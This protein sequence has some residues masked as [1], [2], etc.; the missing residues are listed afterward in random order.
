MSYYIKRVCLQPTSPD[1]DRELQCGIRSSG[2]LN[3]LSKPYSQR[4]RWVKKKYIARSSKP[5]W[6]NSLVYRFLSWIGI[7]LTL[8]EHSRSLKLDV[9]FTFRP[10]ERDIR[11]RANKLSAYLVGGRWHRNIFHVEFEHH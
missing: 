3:Q 4:T 5:T 8:H 1:L 10:A 6:R 7:R 2:L 11:G 9:N